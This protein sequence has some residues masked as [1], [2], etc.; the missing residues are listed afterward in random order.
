MK[1]RRSMLFVPG[2]NT[3]MVCN[4]FIY[5]PDTVMFDLEDS[6]ALS[7]KDSA[8]LMVF[9]A[10][11]HFVYKNVETAV[12]VNPLDSPYGLLDL[13]AVVRAGTDI[14]R[15]PKTDTVEDV[16]NMQDAIE[17]I[18]EKIG[19]TKKTQ[20]LAAIE[21]AEGV[22]NAVNIARC[23]DRL[24]GIALG[25]EDF[26]RDLHTQRTKQG[27]ELMAARSQILL[28]ARA[29]KIHAFDSVFSDV[30]DKEGFLAEVKYVKG[31]G[32]DGKSLVNPNQ[33]SVL[34]DA[35]APSQ[36]DV[37]W[38]LEVIEAAKEAEE[39]GLGVVSLDGRMV[40]APIIARAKWTLELAVAS[41]MIRE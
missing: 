41:G 1:L 34:H 25:A 8:R 30:K 39:K 31:L 19:R 5:K 2:S 37:D 9:H 26:V 13:E 18:E 7:E 32:F 35:Y 6:V 14:V 20:L 10:L 33:I 12:R 11:Q 22:V 36:T 17:K 29:A 15:L 16:L 38:S 40:D 28:A 23:S 4:A 27:S 24:M 21:S 3:S